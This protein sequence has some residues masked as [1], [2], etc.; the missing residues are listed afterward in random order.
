M[1]EDRP[2]AA[3]RGLAPLEQ[4]EKPLREIRS[5]RGRYWRDHG[6]MALLGMALVGG[7][8]LAIGNDHVAIGALGAVLAISVR[9]IYL[10]SEQLGM[11]WLLTDRRLLGPGGRSIMLLEIEA[12]R[13]LLGDIQI[14]TRSG[15]KQLLKHI[16]DPQT[17]IAEIERARAKR[18]KARR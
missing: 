11:R 9:G 5:D 4:G 14:V 8:L 17:V 13:R 2:V 12:A 1:S 3:D 16:A 6:L 7:V 10:A 15:D 18:R